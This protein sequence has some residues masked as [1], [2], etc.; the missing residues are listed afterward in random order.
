MKRLAVLVLALIAS[1]ALAQE[2]P[3]DSRGGYNVKQTREGPGCHFFRPITPEPNPS[4][5][6]LWGNATNT[7]VARYAP[8]LSHWASHGFIVGAAETGNAGSGRDMLACLDFLQRENAREGSVFFGA[9]DASRV[10]AS[11]H[12]QGATGAMMAGR[13]ARITATAPI[14]PATRG[15]F[16]QAGAEKKQHGPMLLLSGSADTITDPLIH[17]QFVFEDANVPVVWATL[18]GAGHNAPAVQDSGPFRPA[19]TA[20][21]RWQL[22]GDAAARALF[23]GEGCAYCVDP[24]WDVRRRGVE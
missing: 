1:P 22:M 12:S 2:S 3:Y 23:A 6:I 7:M 13:D 10:G 11:G 5:V 15:A 18:L 24:G 9:V 14:E 21:F 17:H 20:W 16:Y 8:M 19:I 4:P